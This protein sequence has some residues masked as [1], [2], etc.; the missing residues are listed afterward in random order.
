MTSISVAA[1]CHLTPLY[2]YLY[3]YLNVRG[4]S[5]GGRD[6][7]RELLV[8]L[9]EGEVTYKFRDGDPDA[10]M[11]V[12]SGPVLQKMV[13][14]G[15]G[16]EHSKFPLKSNFPLIFFTTVIIKYHIIYL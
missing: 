11:L 14:F 1:L 7:D 13:G 15:Y 16:S 4:D 10:G 2:L 5:C 3:L 8:V 6:S 12:R 9:V